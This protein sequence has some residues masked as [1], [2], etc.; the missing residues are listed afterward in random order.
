MARFYLL[1][2][3]ISVILFGYSQYKGYG[4]FDDTNTDH[5]RGLTARST[6]HK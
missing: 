1:V 3:L 5:S 2:G 4:L 6:Y